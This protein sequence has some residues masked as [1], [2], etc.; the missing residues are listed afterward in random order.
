MAISV[1]VSSLPV[2]GHMSV[3]ALL[4]VA[5]PL[6]SAGQVEAPAKCKPCQE[7][8]ATC[9]DLG[10][11]KCPLFEE[12]QNPVFLKRQ[13]EIKE[14]RRIKAEQRAKEEAEEEARKAQEDAEFEAQMTLEERGP[15]GPGRDGI[16]EC[17]DDARAKCSD[18]CER[19]RSLAAIADEASWSRE[20][21][22]RLD[23]WWVATPFQAGL[24]AC[25][26]AFTLHLAN[27]FDTAF[28]ASQASLTAPVFLPDLTV[29][30]PCS[31][32]I[33]QSPFLNAQALLG[34]PPMASSSEGIAPE[35]GCDWIK[36]KSAEL[37]LPGF[38][39]FPTDMEFTLPPIPRLM[40]RMQFLESRREGALLAHHEPGHVTPKADAGGEEQTLAHHEPGHVTPKAG[41]EA[42]L[43]AHHEP[44]TPKAEAR[45]PTVVG[46]SSELPSMAIGALVGFGGTGSILFLGTAAARRFQQEPRGR[47]EVVK[48]QSTAGLASV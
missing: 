6:L 31:P 19:R 20:W 37:Q 10:C 12:G 47:I 18:E 16:G 44:G 27:R 26:G 15:E 43:V 33:H 28:R 34:K 41:V 22:D 36:E 3:L 14:K 23:C 29:F 42:E 35:A 11:K 13:E 30:S 7:P 4:L 25:M 9:P 5:G 2:V 24:S 17:S 32:C 1:P 48:A 46:A 38:P 39:D 45:E 40:P 21:I 8:C